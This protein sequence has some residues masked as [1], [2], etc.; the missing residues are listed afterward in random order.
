LR[1][2]A[3]DNRQRRERLAA[4]LG[5]MVTAAEYFVDG[6]LLKVKASAPMAALNEAMEYLI[7]NTFSKMS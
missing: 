4:L 6:Q 7:R 2:C 3:Q 5:E 1:D